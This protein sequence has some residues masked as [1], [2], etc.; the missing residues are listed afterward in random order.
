[1]TDY[2]LGRAHGRVEITADTS[3]AQ[4]AL[5]D[6]ERS[7]RRATSASQDFARVEEEVTKRRREADVAARARRDSEA[8]YRR[9]MQ[10]STSTVEEQARAEE[11]RNRR[12][13][14]S[15]AATARSEQ[16]ERAYRSAVQGNTDA[17]RRFIS[18]LD[19]ADRA[20]IRSSRNVRDFRNEINETDRTVKI[21]AGT[22]T[23]TLMPALKAAGLL[24]GVGAAGGVVGLLGGGGVT[25]LVAVVEAIKD[26]S[27]AVAL[28]PAVV[29]GAA[30]VLGTLAVAFNGVG[31]ALGAIEDP[32][33]FTEALQKLAP[34]AAEVVKILA[35]FNDA[36]K[37]AMMQV[38]QELF[39]PLVDQIQPLVMTWLPALM[40]AG[41]EIAGVFGQAGR[42]LA[43]WLQQPAQMQAFQEFIGNIAQALRQMLPAIQ[44]IADAFVRLSVV[45]SSFFPQIADAIVTIANEFNN[46]VQTAAND[47]S[48]QSWIQSA[49]TAFTQLGNSILNVIAAFNNI[50]AAAG[51]GRGMLD[52]L[53]S[54]TQAF[55]DWTESAEGA[56][57]IASFFQHMSEASQ[58]LGPVLRI[59]GVAILQLL[60]NLAQLGTAMGP[61]IISFFQSFATALNLLGQYLIQAGP[62]L[63]EALMAIGQGL[64]AVVTAIGPSL[65]NLF[66]TLAD[67]LVDLTPT[68]I[69]L[70]TAIGNFFAQLTPGQLE[71][72]LGL[73]VALQAIS[74]IAPIVV[75]AIGAI[76]AVAAALGV[77]LAAATGII[78]GVVVAIGLLVAGGIY[79]VTHWDEVKNVAAS[80]W[81]Q[82]KNFGSWIATT[83]SNIWR[84]LAEAVSGA[85]NDIINAITGAWG[86]I[87]STVSGWFEQAYNWGRTIVQR[88]IDGIKDMFRPLSDAWDWLTGG[89]IDDKN[90]HSPPKKGPLSGDGDPLAAGQRVSERFAQGVTA[91]APAVGKAYDGAISSGGNFSSAGTAGRSGQ[92]FQRNSGFDQWIDGL[93]QDLAAWSKLFRDSFGLFKSVADMF[94]NATNIVASVWNG[95][96]NP[97]T[98]P[99][100]IAGPP[101]SVNQQSVPGVPNAP[102]VKGKAPM[103]ELT[104]EHYQKQGTP[105]VEQQSVPGVP[106]AGKPPTGAAPKNPPANTQ[107]QAPPAVK[108]GAPTAIPTGIHQT[109]DGK[110]ATD[111][112]PDQIAGYIIQK[113]RQLGLNDAQ[114]QGALATAGGESNYGRN[115]YGGD[116]GI[117]GAWGVYQQGNAYGAVADRQNPMTAIDQ[118][119]NL[120]AGQ[121]KAQPGM[122]PIQVA[123]GVQQHGGP[124]SPG[125]WQGT[126]G[127]KWYL[128]HNY[129]NEGMR[130]AS[131]YL[132]RLGTT[133]PAKDGGGFAGVTAS[134][135][136]TVSRPP[137]RLPVDL[138]NAE[139]DGSGFAGVTA[140]GTVTVDEGGG[141]KALP[142]MLDPNVIGKPTAPAPP[143]APKPQPSAFQSV[144]YGLPHGTD[145]GG[146]GTGNAKTFPPWV[147]AL[148]AQYNVKPS[149]YGG[150]QEDT[151]PDTTP[152]RYQPNPQGFNRGIDW[153]GSRADLE[154]FAQA[155]I[156]YGGAEGSG[157]PLE[158]V[159]Y[160]AGPGGRRYGLGGS[161]NVDPNYYPADTYAGHGGREDNIHVHTRFNASVPANLTPGGVQRAAN[162]PTQVQG[163]NPPTPGPF[164]Q[165]PVPFLDQWKD[166]MVAGPDQ[167]FPGESHWEN[168]I[169][170]NGAPVGTATPTPGQP[171]GAK[172]NQPVI[173]GTTLDPKTGQ[174]ISM[175]HTGTGQFPGPTGPTI[176][177]AAGYDPFNFTPINAPGQQQNQQSPLQQ[178]Q[179]TMSS[180]GSIVGDA[181]QVFDDVIKNISAAADI[182][183]QLV[184]GVS[185]TEEVM[186]VIDNVQTFIN[187]AADIAKLTSSVLGMAGGIAGAGAG[188]DPS[189]GAAGAAA[190]LQTASAIASLIQSGLQATNM[191]I[192]IGQEVWHQA[193]KIGA[194]IAAFTLGN[195]QT[196][197]L[198]G[199]VRMLLNTQTGQVYAY[200]QDNPDNKAVHN[201][202]DWFSRAYG[203]NG[204]H[205]GTPPVQATQLNIYAGP[206]QSTQQMMSDSMWLV[207]TGGASV[208]SVSGAD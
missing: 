96:D 138:K 192:D 3:G 40:R 168:I 83:F 190:A 197:P 121:I 173:Y 113:G 88:M 114:I 79:L 31:D 77:G 25:G 67:V 104:P 47:G 30:T 8:A 32:A 135:E 154:A 22:L 24:G 185:N 184:R 205:G 160:Q 162:Q 87:S 179:S 16:A 171:F 124:G 76:T 119:L 86:S 115:I 170:P 26:F 144:P 35:S 126:Q 142:G 46:W 178:F 63:S 66:Q 45:G 62:G 153:A 136:A 72:I 4:R 110:W 187:T 85:W 137:V 80:L 95:G 172:P 36:F 44:P 127:D 17:V 107:G 183:H 10:D 175:P 18:T 51:Q 43:E 131:D 129:P 34:A 116:Q 55:R 169:G 109:G 152:G 201:L 128:S 92:G 181:F 91:G 28:M 71:L 163:A 2:N 193:T 186:G 81:D 29:G 75:T 100:G 15:I 20:H 164:N 120:Y 65:P 191:A 99:G 98:R 132:S 19:D 12:R 38:Q 68:L 102:E 117:G 140:S 206:G 21:L 159:I 108:G 123:T 60:D 146:Y 1:M 199:N 82:L 161:G 203:G 112:T 90:P 176:G 208:A 149:T 165:P 143:P 74:T 11:E 166:V 23:S 134:G 156:A 41:Q 189:G 188:A 33:K 69:V 200:S 194:Q 147:M 133:A 84:S 93:T 125:S 61:G 57:M 174:P 14:E 182:T 106:S 5:S 73:V 202:P 49:L 204:T 118:F 59:I 78:A 195:D 207:S 53:V 48:L 37:G 103:P 56:S 94:V 139:E 89:A 177:G 180:V 101:K 122:S 105:A 150:H 111:A 148:A 141:K 167:T 58:T 50:G 157:G 64:V 130:S 42:M 151:H 54:I 27:G 39:A 155:L 198:G 52:W 70:A 97:L 158:Q 145:T 6:Y 13:N 9:V 196:G 7:T